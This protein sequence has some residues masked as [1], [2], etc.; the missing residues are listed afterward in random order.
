MAVT[1]TLAYNEME[2][3]LALKCF[4]E[5]AKKPVYIKLVLSKFTHNTCKIGHFNNVEKF[6]ISL[7]W[8]SFTKIDQYVYMRVTSGHFIL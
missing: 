3:I 5:L 4:I 6:L 2:L 7:K 8:S 1:N